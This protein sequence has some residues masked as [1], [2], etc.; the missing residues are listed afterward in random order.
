MINILDL[1]NSISILLVN[2]KEGMDF[3]LNI[4][5]IT[6]NIYGGIQDLILNNR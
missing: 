3:Q 2:I 5:L 6:W 1:L 4:T